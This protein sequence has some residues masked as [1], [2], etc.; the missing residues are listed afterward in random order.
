MDHDQDTFCRQ[1]P[2]FKSTRLPIS[3]LI[4]ILFQSLN[5]PSLRKDKAFLLRV[6]KI[7][8][9]CMAH[10][11]GPVDWGEICHCYRAQGGFKS[12]FNYSRT[13]NTVVREASWPFLSKMT[14]QMGVLCSVPFRCREGA[15]S[16]PYRQF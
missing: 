5:R 11:A 15:I 10:T 3:T 4:R 9:Q 7:E 12:C 8:L 14:I 2:Y 16:S 1:S 6:Q 13:K